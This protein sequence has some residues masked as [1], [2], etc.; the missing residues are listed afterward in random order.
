MK[1]ILVLVVMI[2]IV[3]QQQVGRHRQNQKNRRLLKKLL[4]D[5]RF[6]KGGIPNSDRYSD[7]SNYLKYKIGSITYNYNME[8]GFGDPN[9]GDSTDD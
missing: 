5:R 1:K 7:N 6:K 2:V 3:I 4:K 9:W 8:Y